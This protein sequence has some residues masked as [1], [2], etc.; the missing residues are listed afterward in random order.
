MIKQQ[1][2]LNGVI[3][4]LFVGAVI[5]VLGYTL[6]VNWLNEEQTVEMEAD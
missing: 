4:G 6:F 1:E 5:F 2:K 3:I